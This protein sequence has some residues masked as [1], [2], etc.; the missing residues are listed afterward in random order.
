MFCIKVGEKKRMPVF[1]EWKWQER[2]K[3][4]LVIFHFYD[5]FSKP[6]LRVKKYEKGHLFLA[7]HSKVLSAKKAWMTWT[8][9]YQE[10]ALLTELLRYANRINGLKEFEKVELRAKLEGVRKGGYDPETEDHNADRVIADT[11]EIL[12]EI[13]KD[14]LR[15]IYVEKDEPGLDLRLCVELC[16][17]YIDYLKKTIGKYS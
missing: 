12:M 1:V 8:L 2:F 17:E 7:R 4:F 11:S 15:F 13:G 5:D 14:K 3:S 9:S 16:Q 6:D 10:L